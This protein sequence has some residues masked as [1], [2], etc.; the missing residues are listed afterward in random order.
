LVLGSEKRGV[1]MKDRKHHNGACKMWQAFMAES[2]KD[3]D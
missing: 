2:F 1:T 3:W